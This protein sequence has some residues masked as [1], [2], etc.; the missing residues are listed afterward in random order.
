VIP[1]ARCMVCGRTTAG[2]ADLYG[3]RLCGRAT[4]LGFGLARSLALPA[5]IVCSDLGCEHCPGV[6]AVEA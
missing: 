5:C 6:G 1:W 4:C 3:M 2:V